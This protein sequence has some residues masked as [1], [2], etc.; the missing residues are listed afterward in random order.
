MKYE[1]KKH[2]K[3]FYSVKEKPSITIA[4]RQ[5]YIMISGKGNPNNDDFSERVGVLYS[6][7]Y[8]IKMKYKQLYANSKLDKQSDYSDFAVFPLEGVWTS[9]N[10][11]NPL[12]KDS[13]VYTIMIKQ[14][15]FITKEMFK[16]AYEEVRKKKPSV[17]LKDVIFEEMEDC[18][19]I[20]ILHSGTFDSEP[21]S[22]AKMDIF[23]KDNQLERINYYH[24]EIY[25][26]DARK[27]VPEKRKTILRYQVKK[28]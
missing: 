26:S 20:Q 15:N 11:S 9:S 27:T 8:S 3:E 21:E 12:D 17:L 23:A 24:R 19:C 2:E 25:L 7:A 4:P 1:W 13:F 16:E 6:L 10:P 18:E 5:N 14:P 22:F 28:I